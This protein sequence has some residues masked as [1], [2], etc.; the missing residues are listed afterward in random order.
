MI[1]N[2]IY[3]DLINLYVKAII[4]TT[5]CQCVFIVVTTYCIYSYK[6]S[7]YTIIVCLLQCYSLNVT[8]EH[9]LTVMEIFVARR[10]P[11]NENRRTDQI[12]EGHLKH[13]T[14][15]FLGPLKLG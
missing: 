1:R 13:N 15:P 8:Y 14:T 11:V 3:S 4:D 2:L 10:D 6:S 12:G 9:V 5:I 7:I